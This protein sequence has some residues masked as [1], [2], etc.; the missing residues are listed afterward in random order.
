MSKWFRKESQFA[1]IVVFHARKGQSPP[2]KTTTLQEMVSISPNAG[3]ANLKEEEVMSEEDNS[4]PVGGCSS[5]MEEENSAGP[6]ERCPDAIQTGSSEGV[7]SAS[8]NPG[9]SGLKKEEEM[10]EEEGDHSGFV[11]GCSLKIEEEDSA[12]PEAGRCPDTIQIQSCGGFRL[13]AEGPSFTP[14]H[15]Q[16]LISQSPNPGI[17]CL[18]TE[19]EVEEEYLSSPVGGCLPKLEKEDSAVPEAR[20]CP[21]A[22]QTGSSEGFWE[23]TMQKIL[24]AEDLGGGSMTGLPQGDLGVISIS[25]NPGLSCL[26][27]EEE[28][29]EEETD[30]SSYAEGCSPKMEEEEADGPE[31]RR[32]PDATQTRSSERFW[33]RNV[34]KVLGRD[35]SSSDVRHQRFR[36]FC[37]QKAEGPREVCS[38]ILDLCNNWLQPE[39]HTKSQMVDLVVLEQFLSILPAEMESW[40]REC[41]AETSSQ[42]VALAEGFLLRQAEATKQEEQQ[43]PSKE[44][45]GFL[46]AEKAPPD[47]K[48][49]SLLRGLSQEGDGGTIVLGSGLLHALPSR[50]SLVCDGIENM[51]VQSDQSPVT[52]DE[53]VA[54]FAKELWALD[55]TQRAL[56]MEVL[57]DGENVA[58]LAGDRRE[59]KK[60]GEEQ[61]KT[62][63]AKQ[64]Q[65]RK[66]IAFEGAGQSSLQAYQTIYPSEVPYICSECGKTF[67]CR[68][69]FLMHF[70]THVPAL[71][72]KCSECGMS[73]RLK[74]KFLKHLSFHTREKPYDCLESG[75]SFSQSTTQTQPYA[76]HTGEMQNESSE[77]TFRP[78]LVNH[79]K[80]HSEEELYICSECGKGLISAKFLIQHQKTHTGEKQCKC[81]V[82]GKSCGNSSV[83]TKHYRMHRGKK[84]YRCSECGMSFNQKVKLTRHQRIHTEE[85]RYKCSECGKSFC[86]YQSLA[87][88]QRIHTGEKPYKCSECGKSFSF[89]NSFIRHQKIH[90]EGEKAY[91]CLCGEAFSR[92]TALARHSRTHISKIRSLQ[93]ADEALPSHHPSFHHSPLLDNLALLK[94]LILA[95]RSLRPQGTAFSGPLPLCPLPLQ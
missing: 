21:D 13:H 42:A 76:T 57:L 94:Q 65:G 62:T 58:S 77:L 7:V 47:P 88:H 45:T 38:R 1:A 12:D 89:S 80:N 71:P 40:I 91:R 79:G 69:N 6:E 75:K 43:E 15:L 8:P 27:K 31:A 61:R 63:V 59:S 54:C 48:E 85:M 86:L 46:E 19:E 10:E 93:R 78:N 49:K 18:K 35:T 81:P 37:Y 22:I 60:K 87:N 83:L 14:S 92:I 11:E 2:R 56:Q 41:G 5:K 17:S 24:G 68:K 44:A 72:Y 95:M 3:I 52:W 32:C 16:N 82:C 29:E 34:Q 33:E 53:V 90:R 20:R 25:T 84:P 23:G 74:K 9:S 55:P 39:R 36:E 73:F 50:P 28:M 67:N 64:K 66:P 70:R 30:H 26:K 51:A 4:R